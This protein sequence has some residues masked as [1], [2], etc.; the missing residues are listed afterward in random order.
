M[1]WMVLC[2]GIFYVSLITLFWIG[3]V[4]LKPFDCSGETCATFVTVLIPMRNEE[5]NI[6]LLLR[7][8]AKQDYPGNLYEILIID[9]HSTDRSM[10]EVAILSLRNKHIR[11]LELPDG[12]TGKKK[13]LQ[14]GIE[15]SKGE[16]IITCDADCTMSDNWIKSHACYYEKY[17]P[18]MMLGPVVGKYHNTFSIMQSLEMY[19][20]LGSAAGSASLFH[21][22][23]CNGAN[24]SFRKEIYP[25][26]QP[27]YSNPYVHSGDDMF[28]LQQLKKKYRYK[29]HFIKSVNCI[30]RTRLTDSFITFI[31]QRRRW[32]AKAL[33][34]S[35]PDII[36]TGMVVLG[37][38]LL[39]LTT[40]IYGVIV[41]DLRSFLILFFTKCFIDGLFLYKITR[42]YGDKRIMFW[43]PLTECFYF[44]YVCFTVFSS[45][46]WSI[47]WKNRTI[48]R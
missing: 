25:E 11:T 30:V 35:D 42:F 43:F 27:V 23:L 26:I 47:T 22:T 21:A 41:A 3:W 45:M 29:I 46:M 33:N 39:L 17:N 34:Y 7:D 48:K 32:T 28:V 36:V 12:Y 37:I 19:G 2:I 9:D 6:K 18:V 8:L 20:L 10:N 31:Q 38:N 40:I 24:L 14:F 4:N 13:A 16:L 5:T 15:Q 1:I 44:L